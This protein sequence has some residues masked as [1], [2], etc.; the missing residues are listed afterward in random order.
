MAYCFVFKFS[1]K[2]LYILTHPLFFNCLTNILYVF[3]LHPPFIFNGDFDIFIFLF[4]VWLM[5]E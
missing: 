3:S 2:I 1:T 4:L 5:I